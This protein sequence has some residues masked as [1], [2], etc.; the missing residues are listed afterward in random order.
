[1]WGERGARGT[2][3]C[4]CGSSTLTSH[5]SPS[6]SS[7]LPLVPPQ[8]MEEALEELGVKVALTFAEDGSG[9]GA[10]LTAVVAAKGR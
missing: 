1:M 6:P 7:P 5:S 9:K 10:A 4:V 3:R 2:R 8:W